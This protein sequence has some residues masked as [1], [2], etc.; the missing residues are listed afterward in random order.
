[1]TLKRTPVSRSILLCSRPWA[2]R[3]RIDVAHERGTAIAT[4]I[5]G[6]SF[7][8][9]QH[10]GNNFGKLQAHCASHGKDRNDRLV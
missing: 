6:N 5:D 10:F 8:P 2:A 3:V 9:E 4:D 7:E 1:M